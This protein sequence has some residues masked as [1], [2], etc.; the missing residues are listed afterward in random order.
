VQAGLLVV[1]RIWSRPAEIRVHLKPSVSMS[2]EEIGRFY[3]GI[4]GMPWP[5]W[6]TSSLRP[7]LSHGLADPASLENLLSGELSGFKFK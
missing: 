2:I 7:N 3:R 1:S 6:D 4:D 5:D